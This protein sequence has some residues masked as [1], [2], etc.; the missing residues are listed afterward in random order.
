MK[1]NWIS[2]DIKQFVQILCG[3]IKINSLVAILSWL[4]QWNGINI[5]CFDFPDVLCKASRGMSMDKV[6]LL[7]G[8]KM[9]GLLYSTFRVRKFGDRKPFEDIIGSLCKFHHHV[10]G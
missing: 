2:N 4:T 1:T 8:L 6:S 3:I 7:I 9:I 5:K 10:S